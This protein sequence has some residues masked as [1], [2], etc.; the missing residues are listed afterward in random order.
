MLI[1]GLRQLN[2]I[3]TSYALLFLLV[4]SNTL[5]GDAV[6]S[7]NQ[8]T[9]Y[10][11]IDAFTQS[12]IE[13]PTSNVSVDSTTISTYYAGRAPLFDLNDRQVGTCAASFLNM[14]TEDGIFTDI[15]NYISVDNGLIVSWFTP[16]TLINL[17]SDN[18]VN[19]MITE[20]IVSASTK[21]GVNP[22]YGQSFNLIVSSDDQKIY[23]QFTRIGAI[24]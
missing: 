8:Q 11:N 22:F 23:F 18:I 24:F 13:I 20:C 7:R 3:K 21:I 10:L 17:G 1:A 16:T 15:S 6:R 19:S 12:L 9:Y 4:I 2:F 5:Y 14:Q